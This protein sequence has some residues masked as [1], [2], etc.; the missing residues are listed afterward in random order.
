MDRVD[1]V[2]VNVHDT[3]TH[4]TDIVNGESLTHPQFYQTHSPCM[5]PREVAP[6]V[7]SSICFP[8]DPTSRR[9]N[10]DALE[11]LL[12]REMEAARA[13]PRETVVELAQAAITMRNEQLLIFLDLWIAHQFSMSVHRSGAN[14]QQRGANS[15][16]HYGLVDTG[17]SQPSG[18]DRVTV[19]AVKQTDNRTLALLYSI[20]LMRNVRPTC[21]RQMRTILIFK[22][23]RR[24]DS[25]N[26]RPL[27]IGRAS[28]RLMHR[29]LAARLREATTLCTHQRGFTNTDGTMVIESNKGYSAVSLDLRMAFDTVGHG[30]I[31]GGLRRKG[32]V[33]NSGRGRSGSCAGLFEFDTAEDLNKSIREIDSTRATE[34][35]INDK[36]EHITNKA[37]KDT[38]GTKGGQGKETSKKRRQSDG[39]EE[40]EELAE[41]QDK[42]NRI[43]RIC[44]KVNGVTGKVSSGKIQF[45]LGD[46]TAVSTC[47]TQIMTARVSLMS[48]F[49]NVWERVKK[50]E[51]KRME[52]RMGRI[53]DKVESMVQLLKE[54][55]DTRKMPMERGMKKEGGVQ[56]P[57]TPTP[58]SKQQ[59]TYA[60]L[61]TRP[62]T[63][64][65][66]AAPTSVTPERDE[67]FGTVV[68]MEGEEQNAWKV[69]QRV[70]KKLE[71]KVESVKA[72]KN[73]QGGAVIIESEDRDQHKLVLETLKDGGDLKGKGDTLMKP[74][75]RITGVTRGYEEVDIQREILSQNPNLGDGLGEQDKHMK[76]IRRLPCRNIMKENWILDTTPVLF[77]KMVKQGTITFDPGVVYVEEQRDVAICYRCCKFGHIAKFCKE[78]CFCYLC[79]KK[80]HEGSSCV[81][82][83]FGCIN[84]ESGE[85]GAYALRYGGEAPDL[86]RRSIATGTAPGRV[87]VGVCVATLGV[88]I[89]VSRRLASSGVETLGGVLGRL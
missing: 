54:N 70:K 83:T 20:T 36:I 53:E 11:S 34:Q 42:I 24:D 9:R 64:S 49:M 87:S 74:K 61:G 50:A 48:D 62:Q 10:G 88:G 32:I 72:V 6:G 51:K 26:W 43:M 59:K 8:I 44:E 31:V 39:G 19:R 40:E 71:G 21:F 15:V 12:R 23:G 82:G 3:H 7:T 73:T 84:C 27:S 25:A 17:R 63:S 47:M 5:P 18:S 14:S 29:I 67:V 30:S 69:V 28:Q 52:E 85:I 33:S 68:R 55:L 86:H 58:T 75:V 89:G 45:N 37:K 1:D 46:K 41:V 38:K 80:G 78:E 2:K 16:R 57:N 79:G 81:E 4:G 13:D 35:R 76:L 65:T 60:N 66:G 22:N 56:A 77:K